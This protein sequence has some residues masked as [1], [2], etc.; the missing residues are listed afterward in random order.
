MADNNDLYKAYSILGSATTA[1][2][3]RR[4][5]EE[6]EYRRKARRDQYLGYL[7]APLLKGAGE[8]IVGGVSGFVGDAIMGGPEKDFFMQT[9]PGL[10]MAS[11]SSRATKAY[12]TAEKTRQ[13]WLKSSEGNHLQWK[14]NQLLAEK[15]ARG[16]AVYGEKDGN[17]DLLN[18][19]IYSDKSQK[20]A[21]DLAKQEWD[22]LNSFLNKYKNAPSLETLEAARQ[23]TALG[24]G[25][26]R[27]VGSKLWAKFRGK[28]YET[29]V[30]QPAIQEILNRGVPGRSQEWY[31]V[32]SKELERELLA[33]V[34][35]SQGLDNFIANLEKSD[36]EATLLL[37]G[38]A[39]RRQEQATLVNMY[40]SNP[41]MLL[42]RGY[43]QAQ[44]EAIHKSGGLVN[45]KVPSPSAVDQIIRQK[46]KS[47]L[48]AITPSWNTNEL[49]DRIET[50]K[51]I[52]GTTAERIDN[53]NE[54][55]YQK[56]YADIGK[57]IP[58]HLA[59]FE[60][61]NAKQL[62]D[63]EENFAL[64][65]VKD[66][67]E[68]LLL[69][70]ANIAQSLVIEDIVNTQDSGKYYS[71]YTESGS[72]K[73]VETEFYQRLN[74]ILESGLETENVNVLLEKNR[75]FDDIVVDRNILTGKL[76][77][78]EDSVQVKL[79]N[80]NIAEQNSQGLLPL[81]NVWE[82]E[83]SS[84]SI[85]ALSLSDINE[86]LTPTDLKGEGVLSPKG[87]AVRKVVSLFDAEY[88]KDPEK[89]VSRLKELMST[90][91]RN[92]ED[93]PPRIQKLLGDSEQRPF[94]DMGF[95]PV[96]TGFKS[97]MQSLL[98]EPSLKEE[99]LFAD[100]GKVKAQKRIQSLDSNIAELQRQISGDRVTKNTRAAQVRQQKLDALIEERASLGEAPVVT[101]DITD[102][103]SEK[104]ALDKGISNARVGKNTKAFKARLEQQ[105]ELAS[106]LAAMPVKARQIAEAV[107]G[108]RNIDSVSEK[109]LK[110]TLT[111]AYG[112]EITN[113]VLALLSV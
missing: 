17:D 69:G 85:P 65:F 68:K 59:T 37:R 7:A 43:T 82:E 61:A 71:V 95:T 41:E 97:A 80:E 28:D 51:Q 74:L 62:D 54:Q 8:A 63:Q 10:A 58:S 44:I 76:K 4:R 31:D 9:E 66:R 36:P 26:A 102:I 40:N 2:Y 87:A 35:T 21:L 77:Q 29:E 106:A 53:L 94:I 96:D 91:S 12:K 72:Q 111:S 24:K 98:S 86:K 108:L 25:R 30:V 110:E 56:Y 47:E 67:R 55:L 6:D 16:K 18:E 3:N 89:A 70:A 105:D 22:E 27:Q 15:M 34:N 84:M 57:V 52:G 45:G 73:E 107:K 64:A 112:T 13:E 14:A 99:G 19:I 46:V 104:L 109:D 20:E 11:A 88:D 1:E 81:N 75:I 32:N 93:L 33:A 101:S 60:E 50:F 92:I 42:D 49:K 90:G 78:S 103:L 113:Q 5:K 39:K 100:V 83:P 79:I 23:N 38:N 48:K